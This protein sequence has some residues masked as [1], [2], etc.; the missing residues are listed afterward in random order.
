MNKLTITDG[1]NRFEIQME[2]KKYIIGKNVKKKRK[3]ELM[4]KQFFQ[5]TESEYRCEYNF[6]TKLLLNDEIMNCKRMLFLE[7]SPYY[8]LYEDCKLNSKSLVL[9]Y[10]EKKLQ[11]QEYFD[12]INTLDIL[13]KSFAEELN[14]DNLNILFHEMNV[15]QLLKILEV[16]FN[17]DMQKDEFDL[18]YEEI[19][20]LQI[21]LINEIIVNTEDK[22]AIVVLANIPFITDELLDEL[23]H[24]HHTFYFIFTNN[25]C[26]KMKIEE[27]M[28]SEKEFYD[29][30][31]VN[32]IFY[33][34]EEMYNI[35]QQVE[36]LKE[37]MKNFVKQNYMY[38]EINVIN[39]LAHFSKNS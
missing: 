15:K 16:Y 24:T 6:E 33:N 18:S 11:N 27:V 21:H 23:K 7:I 9:K 14:D 10:L 31:D 30:A 34:I 37:N 32:S 28:L 12:T 4:I 13:F 25:Y 35:I 3:L 38:N 29:L 2:N 20:R 8:S 26:N 1:N 19:I 17:D 22:D 36:V 5:K 39:E